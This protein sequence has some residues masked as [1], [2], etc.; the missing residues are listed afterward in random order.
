LG[1]GRGVDNPT[2]G[3]NVCPENLRGASDR[4]DE[5]T[6]NWLQGKGVDFWYKSE[7]GS[8]A[9]NKAYSSLQSIFRSKQITRWADVVQRDV[10][11]LLRIRGWR[12]KAANRDE[13]RSLMREA[14][15]RK[16]L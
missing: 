5:Y 8:L 2:P 14:K 9:A 4:I 1:V 12:S 3:K 6:T 7:L 15:A 11:H 13:W 10:L 16:G